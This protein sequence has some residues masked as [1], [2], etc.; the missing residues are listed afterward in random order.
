MR[1]TL[2]STISNILF[3]VCFFFSSRTVQVLLR[4]VPVA[5]NIILTVSQTIF[6]QRVVGWKNLTTVINDAG[7]AA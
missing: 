4:N 2:I 6:D 1:Q 3:S 7:I 5:F